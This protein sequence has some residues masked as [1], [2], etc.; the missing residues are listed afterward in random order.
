MRCFRGGPE[1]PCAASCRLHG[2]SSDASSNLHHARCRLR[3]LGATARHGGGH[4]VR[5]AARP[6]HAGPLHPH[7]LRV[8]W[9]SGYLHRRSPG[10]RRWPRRLQAGLRGP[11]A[12]PRP[13]HAVPGPRR[14][15]PRDVAEAPPLHAGGAA[16]GDAG[17]HRGR[18]RL[19][20]GRGRR[21]C[22]LG[23]RRLRWLRSRLGAGLAH[24]RA[25]PACRRCLGWRRRGNCWRGSWRLQ[26]PR[27]RRCGGPG[28]LQ[29][30]QLVG[31]EAADDVLRP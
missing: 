24:L 22:G 10:C 31:H 2:A 19:R 11:A 13:G 12:R 20:A 26:W 3:C 5:F 15:A 23:V 18:K 6:H 4:P 16:P 7:R 28:D 27:G 30:R 29:A 14:G 9:R 17:P 21:R 25:L 1:G 8:G